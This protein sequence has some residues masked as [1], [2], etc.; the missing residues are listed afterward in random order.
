MKQ[1]QIFFIKF[2]FFRYIVKIQTIT[3]RRLQLHHFQK[4]FI[5]ISILTITMHYVK[6]SVD[7]LI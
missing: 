5:N 2:D 7:F 6:K 4:N 3:E 1:G